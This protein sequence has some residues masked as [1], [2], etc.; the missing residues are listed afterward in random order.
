MAR[1]VSDKLHWL[2]DMVSEL[3]EA[4]RYLQRKVKSQTARVYFDQAHA[5]LL[6]AVSA[7]EKA[8]EKERSYEK[9]GHSHGA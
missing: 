1:F 5:L 7:I 8:E 9:G 3:G 6:Q 2:G 4:A